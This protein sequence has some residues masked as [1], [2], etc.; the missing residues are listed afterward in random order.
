MRKKYLLAP[1]IGARGN[2]LRYEQR[3]DKAVTIFA[4]ASNKVSRPNHHTKD[5][6]ASLPK[7]SI[8]S[9]S[10]CLEEENI[11]KGGVIDPMMS[12]QFAF[13]RRRGT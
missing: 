9:P 12:R 1:Q 13:F 2:I 5:I 4:V 6:A 10:Q 7:V 11:L 3:M 8:F